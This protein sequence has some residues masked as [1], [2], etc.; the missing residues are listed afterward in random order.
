[1]I[2]RLIK[3]LGLL[4]LLAVLLLAAVYGW[5]RW[6]L[7]KAEQ[8]DKTDGAKKAFLAA[9]PSAT[10]VHFDD[11][12]CF[13]LQVSAI[14]YIGGFGEYSKPLLSHLLARKVGH[15]DP[16]VRDLAAKALNR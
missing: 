14:R 5:F 4:L 13:E 15:W 2:V 16:A 10:Y 11:F 8:V 7:A 9:H 6:Q 3:I 1:M 12:L